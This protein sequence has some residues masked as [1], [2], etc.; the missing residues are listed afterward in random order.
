MVLNNINSL[1]KELSKVVG[2]RALSKQIFDTKSLCDGFVQGGVDFS[3]LELL[4][5]RKEH[6][7]FWSLYRLLKC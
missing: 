6:Y 4:S 1:C 3:L 7:G 5:P 2:L